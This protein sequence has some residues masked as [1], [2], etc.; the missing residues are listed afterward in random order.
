MKFSKTGISSSILMKK[1]LS[2]KALF[3]LI[4][5]G[6]FLEEKLDR[7]VDVVPKNALRAELQATV[8]EDLIK[9]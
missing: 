9:I 7:K 6:L 4:G 2:G 5:F 3:D 8:F 1:H